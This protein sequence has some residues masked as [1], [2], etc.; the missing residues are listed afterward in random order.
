MSEGRKRGG[1]RKGRKG[2]LKMAQLLL[3]LIPLAF[4]IYVVYKGMNP[5][6]SFIIAAIIVALL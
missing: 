2:G 1:S 4:V 5:T 3:L 6:L